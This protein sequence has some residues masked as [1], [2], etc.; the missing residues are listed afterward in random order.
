MADCSSPGLA[1][2]LYHIRQACVSSV[3]EL[4]NTSIVFMASV[5]L[6]WDIGFFS[7]FKLLEKLENKGLRMA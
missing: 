1:L 7:H 5:F 6:V 4:C 2:G 3:R